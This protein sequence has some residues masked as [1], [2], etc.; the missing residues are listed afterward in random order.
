MSDP[1]LP[2]GE[3]AL[4]SVSEEMSE[5]NI[6]IAKGK[7]FGFDTPN[8]Y[9]HGTTPNERLSRELGDLLGSI[10]FLLRHHP[11]I[12]YALVQAHASSRE[13]RLLKANDRN[14]VWPAVTK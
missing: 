1:I 3:L 9:D 4:V 11:G 6:E 13:E 12:D 10:D 7:R 8:P 2:L 14:T 5:V